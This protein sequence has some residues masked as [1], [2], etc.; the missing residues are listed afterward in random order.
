MRITEITYS[1]G[2]TIQVK[3]YHPRVFH[4]SI[5]AEIEEAV[6]DHGEILVSVDGVVES[7]KEDTITAKEKLKEI[8]EKM[9]KEDVEE[10]QEMIKKKDYSTLTPLQPQS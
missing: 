4:V 3:D 10:L 2:Q 1:L 7:N 9:I 6:R 5:K 8:A